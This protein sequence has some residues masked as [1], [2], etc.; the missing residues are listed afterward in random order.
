MKQFLSKLVGFS[1]GPIIGALIAFITIPV[2]T[3]FIS[4]EE[5]GK[6]GMFTLY[7]GLVLSLLY[8]GLDQSYTR[9]YH[10][11]DNK[12]NLLK[13]VLVLPLFLTIILFIVICLNTSSISLILFGDPSY[14]ITAITFGVLLIFMVIER[15]LMLSIRMEE[16]AIEFSI[17]NIL[18]KL[19]ILILTLIFILFIRRDFLAVIYSTFFGQVLA[20][21][22]LVIRYRKRLSFKNYYFDKNLLIKLLK[23]GSPLIIA[24]A[25]A[26]L[27][28]SL[29]RISLRIWSTFYEIGILTAALK[30]SATLTIVQTSF[31]NFWVPTAYRWYNQ[32]KS[33]RHFEFISQVILLVMSVCFCFILLFK[34]IIVILLSKDYYDA[35]FI[36]GLLCLQPIMYTVSE[37][38]TL[39]IVF[40]KKSYYHL[41]V[42]LIALLPNIV[43]NILLVPKFGAVGA[44]ISTGFSFVLFFVSRSY[45]SNKNWEGFSVKKHYIIALILF[46][47]AILNTN[48]TSYIINVFILIIILIIQIPT[49]KQIIKLIRKEEQEDWDFS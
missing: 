8:L 6:S 36:I 34:D 48:E 19:G 37:T 2:T 46:L 20:D 31:A 40:S 45:F 42:S 44:A 38:T 14:R 28:N 32:K 3:Y 24:A 23:F 12:D 4:P 35:K 25:M 47:A 11:T 17:V 15:F 18:V 41:W 29:D 13:N 27:L 39:G 10:E 21:A 22:Y 26:N 33:I 9:E 16:K 5:Y 1:F 49:I 7:L 43:L 30:V